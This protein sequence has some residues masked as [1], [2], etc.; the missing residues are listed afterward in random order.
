V[1]WRSAATTFL[2]IGLIVGGVR[3]RDLGS[4]LALQAPPSLLSPYQPYDLKLRPFYPV[5]NRPAG[6]LLHVRI[7]GGQ[8]L[9]LVL[10]SGTEFIVVG[11]ETGRSLGIT[12]GSELELV[13]LGSR[14]ARVGRAETVEVGPVSFRSCPVAVVDGKVVEGA[15]GVIPLSLFSDFLLRLDLPGKTLGLIPYPPEEDPGI[16]PPT[17]S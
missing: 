9:R 14:H 12:G 3:A 5:P 10:D 6:L 4:A 13:G 16:H 7:N 17:D 15:D 2:V 11:P 8:S 1:K